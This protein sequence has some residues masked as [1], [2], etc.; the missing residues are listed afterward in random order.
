MNF[1]AKQRKMIGK[2]SDPYFAV[3][4]GLKNKYDVIYIKNAEYIE[5]NAIREGAGSVAHELSG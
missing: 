4:A 3:G 1:E 2:E 5:D